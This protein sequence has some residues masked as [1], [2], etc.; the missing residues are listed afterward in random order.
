MKNFPVYKDGKEYWV[1]RSVAVAVTLFSYID[2]KLCVLA[3][4]RGKGLPNH[5][6]QWNVISGYLDYD[7]TLR[8]ACT[9]EVFEESGV[10]IK[11]VNLRMM[12]IEDEPSRENQVVLFR[13]TGFIMGAKNLQLTTKNADEGEVEE[14]KW[15]PVEDVDQYE[16]TSEKH[17]LKIIEYGDCIVNMDRDANAITLMI[18]N[19]GNKK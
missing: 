9:R 10:D 1:S 19:Y 4:K 3:N 5:V 13:Y 11:D 8:D 17:M 18:R 7:E 16:W 6:G 12:D 14:V 2:N 15:I